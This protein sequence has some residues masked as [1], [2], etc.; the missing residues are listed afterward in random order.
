MTT[1]VPDLEHLANGSRKLL[2]DSNLEYCSV[3]IQFVRHG[4][5]LADESTW[6]EW[7]LFRWME[8]WQAVALQLHLDPNTVAWHALGV[9]HL[10]RLSISQLYGER[11]RVAVQHAVHESLPTLKIEEQLMRTTVRPW[12]FATWCDEI[13]LPSSPVR[14]HLRRL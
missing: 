13:G 11:M 10:P 8:L 1:I 2:G 9:R 12:E 3:R 7:R 14:T 4:L 6:R 5:K